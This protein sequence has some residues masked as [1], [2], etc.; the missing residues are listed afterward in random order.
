MSIVNT[1]SLERNRQIIINFARGDLTPDA[2]LLL[3]KRVYLP[4]WFCEA[5]KIPVLSQ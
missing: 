3:N 5:F 4:A 1:L 2:G